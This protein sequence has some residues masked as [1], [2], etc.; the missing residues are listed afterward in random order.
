MNEKNLQK[1]SYFDMYEK[2][3][4]E[5][6][7]IPHQDLSY[8]YIYKKWNIEQLRKELLKELKKETKYIEDQP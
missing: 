7:Q 8:Q 5:E 2:I 1:L 6:N 4:F 3:L